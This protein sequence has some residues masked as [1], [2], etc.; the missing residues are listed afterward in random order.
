MK[1]HA[2]WIVPFQLGKNARLHNIIRCA[3]LAQA[4]GNYFRGVFHRFVRLGRLCKQKN[5]I[6]CLQSPNAKEFILPLLRFCDGP[7][8]LHIPLPFWFKF[9]HC[10][11]S[12]SGKNSE[13]RLIA[14]RANRV[15]NVECLLLIQTDAQSR[16]IDTCH[17][18]KSKCIR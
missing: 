7:R 14:M 17:S 11:S 9:I 2:K 15:N 10:T 8:H 18:V 3:K 13:N 16:H 4:L 1:P 5:H 6:I 12:F